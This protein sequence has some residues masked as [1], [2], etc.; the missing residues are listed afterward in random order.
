MAREDK[1]GTIMIL[2]LK[3]SVDELWNEDSRF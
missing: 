2:N 3:W 1:K